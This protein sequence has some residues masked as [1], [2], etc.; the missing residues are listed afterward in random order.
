MIEEIFK[1]IPG[2]EG[3]YQVSNF[4]NVKSLPKEKL[5]KGKYP[6]ISKERILKHNDDGKGYYQ[7]GLSKEGKTKCIKI[8]VLVA[9]AFLGHVPDGTHKLVVDHINNNTLDNRIENL[10]LITQRENASKYF[11]TKKKSSQ[12]IGVSWY[13]KLNKW[14]ANIRIDGKSKRLGLFHDEYQAHL[15]YQ[16]ALKQLNQ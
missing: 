14:E 16:K 7:L 9:Q 15:A 5:N 10:Q 8:H 12:Y 1:D 4:G 13:K 6:F 11:L 2:Y 3:L